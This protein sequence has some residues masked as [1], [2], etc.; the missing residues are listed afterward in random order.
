MKNFTEHLI[1]AKAQVREALEQLDSLGSNLTLFVVDEEN[2]LQGT[3]TDGDVRRGLL[4]GFTISDSVSN[5]MFKDFKFLPKQYKLADIDFLKSK[6]IYFVP[7]LDEIQRISRV[8][9]LNER[10]AVIPVDAV[11]M[12]G[13]KGQRLKPLTDNTPKPLLMV[14]NKPIIEHNI[15]RLIEYGIDT[16]YITI[17]YLGEQL[18]D[19]FG[20]GESKGISINYVKETQP[21]G[22]IGA[23][24]LINDFAHDTVLIMNSDLLTNIDFEEFYR[25]FL[26]EEADMSVATIPYNV[27]IPYAVVEKE[28]SRITSF[29]EKPIYTYYSNAG[30]YLVKKELLKHLPGGEKYNATDFIDLLIQN[31]Y[32]VTHFPLM[33]YWLDIGKFDDYHK[34][35]TDIKSIKF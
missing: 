5:F 25:N 14:G 24:S 35:Q 1:S 12:A 6:K 28:G 19:Y 17:K 18:V 15:D 33:A 30:I 7:V 4:K 8:V 21:L 10:K 34:A 29:K 23:V 32:N 9:N 22:T 31:R 26:K 3:L 16:I 13:G 11:I 27:A 2:R 20:T